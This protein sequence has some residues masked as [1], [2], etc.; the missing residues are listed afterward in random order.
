[1]NLEEVIELYKTVGYRKGSEFLFRWLN[2]IYQNIYLPCI[3]PQYKDKLS[4]D[5]TKLAIFDVLLDDLAD[6][7]KARDNQLLEE[8]ARIPWEKDIKLKNQYIEVGRKI[9]DDVYNS[10]KL[11][12]RYEE[13]KD[14]FFFDLHQIM[15]GMRY[16][17][18]VNKFNIANEIENDVF[19]HHGCMVILHCDMDL[20][21]SL[22]FNLN[23]LGEIRVILYLAQKIASIG[24]ML[25]TYPREIIERDSS[26]PIISLA[27][28][29]G[30]ITKDWNYDKEKLKKLEKIFLKKAKIYINR[31]KKWR[32]I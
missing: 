1:M 10:I 4:L 6:N 24:N 27:I 8:F 29:K 23:E 7:W 5:K 19:T 31:I 22:N 12:P 11:Y 18:L 3:D 16:S 28:K 2:N 26:P 32:T 20:M 9:W 21:C 14:V 17:F 30:Y 25:N 13:L 15:N